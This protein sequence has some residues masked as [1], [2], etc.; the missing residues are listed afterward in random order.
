VQTACILSID[1]V[2]L[3]QPLYLLGIYSAGN[4]TA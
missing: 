3:T 4:I 2:K 1:K